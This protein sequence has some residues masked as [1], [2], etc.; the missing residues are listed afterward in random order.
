[1]TD[2][3][4]GQTG[5]IQWEAIVDGRLQLVLNNNL[6]ALDDARCRVVQHF[7]AE[8]LAP[9]VINRL[10][11]IFEEV[12]ANIMRHGFQPD[13][14]QLIFIQA[15]ALPGALELVFEDDG[16]P[17]NPQSVAPPSRFESLETAKIGGLGVHLVSR[18]AASTHYRRVSPGESFR[19]L[20]N[21]RFSPNNR[22]T[23][24]IA[25]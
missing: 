3:V 15:G 6:T 5:G 23:L 12:V 18:L 4:V 17:F 16:M 7:E 10:E 21:R 1:L 8:N 20:G 13:S 22:L 25:K 11:V 14:D 19:M 9:L 2:T 24:S